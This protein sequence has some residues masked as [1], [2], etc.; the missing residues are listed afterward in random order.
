[1]GETL[2]R[3]GRRSKSEGKGE[4]GRPPWKGKERGK[5]RA[6]AGALGL[7]TGDWI[8][9]TTTCTTA[10]LNILPSTQLN[11]FHPK[12]RSFHSSTSLGWF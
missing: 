5:E 2:E 10:R 6:R 11:G 4:R 7:G 8:T 1:M 3:Q 12:D 9:P